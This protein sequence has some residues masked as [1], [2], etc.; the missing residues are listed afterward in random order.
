M[1]EK[2]HYV[3]AIKACKDFKSKYPDIELVPEEEFY[4]DAPEKIKSSKLSNDSSHDLMLKRLNYELHQRK[5]LCKLHEK[6]EQHKKS[7]LETIA[8]RKKFLS[9]LPS[10]L[11][12]LKKA[13]LPVQNQLGV[14]HTKKIKQHQSAELL[15]PPLYVIYSQL[16]AQKEAFAE[17]IDLEIVGSLKDA[18]TFARQQAVKDTGITTNVE[19]SKL[20]DDV[21]DDDDDGQRRR[22]RP[23]RVPSKE[24]V[25][26]AGLYQVHPLKIFLHINDDEISNPKCAKLISLKFEYLLKLNLVCVG[27]EGS[28]EGPAKDILCNLF[29]DDTGLELPHQSAKLLVG[30]TLV[31]DE[32]RTSRPYK[33][34]QHLAGIDFLPEF[35]PLLARCE[36]PSSETAKS[37]AVISGLALYRQ[38]NRVQTVLQRIRSRKKAQLALVE[39]LDSL[40]KLKWPALDFESVPWALH[41]PLCSLHGWSPVGPASNSASSLPSMDIEQIQEHIDVN[42]DGRPASKEELETA[43]EDGEL[44]SLVPVTSVEND[45]K[46]IPSGQ[47]SLIHSRQLALI[48]KSI[49]S[50]ISKA[51]AQSFKKYDDD[52]ELLLDIDSDVE[53]SAQIDADAENAASSHSYELTKKSWVDCGVKEFCLILTRKMSGNE[54]ILKLEAKIKVS[55]E[56]PLRPPLFALSLAEDQ[57]DGN[58]YEWYNELRAMEGEVNLHT[59]KMLPPDQ[60]NHILAH[61]VRCLAMLFDYCLDEASPSEKRKT[62]S[63]VDVGLCKPVDGSLLARSFR[64]R[65]RRRMI[66]WKDMECTLGYPY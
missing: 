30:D 7:L 58:G 14:L 42:L 32:R 2:S 15:P 66:S 65:D 13:S 4:R 33:W 47:S 17:N 50:P 52:S 9:S 6:L 20:E 10:H 11:K 48:S 44:P 34:A 54:K 61:Q 25:D 27:I 19:N 59:V 22:K 29:P 36:T 53:D 35:S 63:V 12:S 51:R 39:H 64:G 57:H 56:Y 1:Y 55:M 16:I 18:Q 31:F 24:N 62:T 43:R 28:H 5:E 26:Q 23:R 21:P 37:D 46:L 60:E 40:M 49:I 3:K 8:N 38:Q 45:V 41:T